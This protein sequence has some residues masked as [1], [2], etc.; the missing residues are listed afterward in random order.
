MRVNGK[1]P[2]LGGWLEVRGC[3]I[4]VPLGAEFR[5]PTVPFNPYAVDGAAPFG[6]ESGILAARIDGHS[7]RWEVEMQDRPPDSPVNCAEE[8]Q[9]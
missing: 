4:T 7:I 2:Q 3:R 6:S 1:S 8:P 5:W 9:L